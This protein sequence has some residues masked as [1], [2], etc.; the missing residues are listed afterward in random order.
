MIPASMATV[1][2]VGGF[3]GAGKTTLLLAAARRLHALGCRAGVI[4]NDQGSDLVD[5]SLATV[6]GVQAEEVSGACF[7][8]RFS[9]LV[10]AAERLLE[11]RPDV[12]FAEPV[13]SCVD[14]AA[15]VVRPLKAYYGNQ[16][17]IAPYSVLIDPA[18][19]RQMLG[20]A[21]PQL[22]YLFNKQIA[23]ADLVYF[24]KCDE[25]SDLPEVPGVTARRLSSRTG[26]S[27]AEW[28]AEV[29]ASRGAANTRMLD[30]N[31]DEYAEAEATLGWLN[32]RG[33]LH[34]R[35]APTSA[36]VAGPLLENLDDH[37]TQA[38]AVIA[39]LK[40]YVQSRTGYVKASICDNGQEPIAEGDL[41]SSPSRKHQI[42]LNLRAKAAPEALRDSVEWAAAKLPGRILV[43]QQQCFRPGRPVPEYR[44]GPT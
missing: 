8:C 42:L 23:E 22:A 37:L 29:L 18:R 30:V 16:F 12:I 17:R 3:L 4:M 7:C 33:S 13:G 25:Y 44:L 15:T 35:R 20:D 21:E 26:E 24:S 1:V 5:S 14:I 40:V 6:A 9:D 36:A 28:L 11:Y 38:G 2:L 31:Y 39:H 27:I 19:A 34:L 41:L 32:W 10:H 43:A